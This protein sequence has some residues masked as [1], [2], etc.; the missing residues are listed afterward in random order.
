LQIDVA[1]LD[2]I[3]DKEI[4]DIDVAIWFTATARFAPFSKRTGCPGRRYHS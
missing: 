4:A 2:A 1:R 3:F